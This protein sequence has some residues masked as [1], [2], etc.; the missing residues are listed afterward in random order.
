MRVTIDGKE[1]AAVTSKRITVDG[2][3]YAELVKPLFPGPSPTH[4]VKIIDNDND[5]WVPETSLG[6]TYRCVTEPHLD[7]RTRK[8]IEQLWGIVR[9]EF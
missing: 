2:I 7:P 3:V 9:E 6:D 5:E 8:D 1:Y 4:P